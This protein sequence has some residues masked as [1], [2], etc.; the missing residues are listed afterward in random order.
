MLVKQLLQWLETVLHIR[1][2]TGVSIIAYHETNDFP[3]PS[4]FKEEFSIINVDSK[5]EYR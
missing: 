4:D 3:F 5:T 2:K 1:V